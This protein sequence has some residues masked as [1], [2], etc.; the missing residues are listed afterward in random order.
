MVRGLIIIPAYNEE[1]TIGA[2]IKE[3]RTHIPDFDIVVV[4]DGSTD[5]TASVARSS[6]VTVL[7]LPFNMGIG[8][9]VQTGYKYAQRKGYPVAVQFDADGQ[10]IAEEVNSLIGPLLREE[11]D[12]VVGSRFLSKGS[13]RVGWARGLGIRILSAVISSVLGSRITDPTSGFRA[14]SRDVIEFFS[15]Y[16]PDDY[17]E[18]ESLV[19]LHKA[20][21]RIQEVPVRMR[22]R[23]GGRSSITP[24][25]AFYY[26]VK[27]LLAILIDL[28]KTVPRSGKGG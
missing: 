13:Y 22:Q 17:P 19:L 7:S 21:F 9:A 8:T 12:F 23:T 26:M 5:S 15:R 16:Y 20:G 1:V 28:F 6:G 14:A 25:R 2:V 18:P 3:I 27:V 4:D 10:H 24:L 11:S